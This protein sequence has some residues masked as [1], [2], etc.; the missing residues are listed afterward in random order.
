MDD[1]RA[2]ELEILPI[3]P[4]RNSVV[5]PASV[6]PI[7]VGR[8]RSV[9]L[10]EDLLGRERATVGIVSQRDAEVDEPSFADLFEVGT[11]ARVVKVIR[12]GPQNYSVVLHGLA[13]LRVRQIGSLEPYM[14]AHVQRLHED[15]ARDA[16]LDALGASLRESMRDLLALVPNL[17]KETGGV[18][19]NVRESGALADLIASNLT[20]EHASVADKQRVLET[21]EP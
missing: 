7:N 14:T 1:P 6:V 15:V 19:E 2:V 4:L 12:L 5:F 20:S 9:R 3:L 16:E 18:L 10:V 13:R 21:L 8:A 17:P 11:L